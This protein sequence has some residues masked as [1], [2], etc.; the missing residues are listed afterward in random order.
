MGMS[1]SNMYSRREVNLQRQKIARTDN[2]K[3]WQQVL[4]N[5]GLV[6][7][8]GGRYQTSQAD[9]K[10]LIQEG[11]L[12]LFD[13]TIGYDPARAKCSTYAYQKIQSKIL[14][15]LVKSTSTIRLP[16]YMKTAVN[17]LRKTEKAMEGTLGRTPSD[18]ELAARLNVSI[19]KIEKIRAASILLNLVPLESQQLGKEQ[20]RSSAAVSALTPDIQAEKEELHRDLKQAIRQLPSKR[21]RDILRLH[22]GLNGKPPL[23]LEEIAERYGVTREAIR[24]AEKRSLITLKKMLHEYM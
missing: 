13:A 3:R 22:F 24:Q 5:L 15:V 20:K 10:D 7:K 16:S 23:T 9:Y 1:I 8:Q 18:E 6:G 14:D 19:E 12:G 4:E 21:D 17:L 11:I 2:V